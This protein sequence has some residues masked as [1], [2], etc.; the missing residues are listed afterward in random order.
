MIEAPF[1]IRKLEN[2]VGS[3]SLWSNGILHT[4]TNAEIEVNVEICE[5]IYQMA[6]KITGGKSYPNLFTFT[7]YVI[8][9]SESRNFMLLPKRLALSCADALVIT[10]LPQK[11]IGNFYLKINQPSI[12]TSLFSKEEDAIKWLL[13][14]SK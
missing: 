7:Q 4:H 12:P 1:L 11:I 6:L 5:N 8:P 9:D 2:N 3:V 13:Q 14:F 10:S